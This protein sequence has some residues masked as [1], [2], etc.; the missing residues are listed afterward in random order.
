MRW[1][2]EHGM[3]VRRFGAGPEV[4]WLHGLGEWSQSFDVVAARRALAGFSHVLPDLPGYGRSPWSDDDRGDGS[5][6]PGSLEQLADQLVEWLGD[7]RPALIGAS[8]GGVLAT[9]VAERTAV[10]AVIDVDGNLSLGDC[11]FSSK[12]LAYSAD[13]FVASGFA[14]L[15]TEIYDA[16]RTDRALRGY[17]AAISAASPRVFH[18]HARELVALSES[19]Q[20]APRLAALQAPALFIA[21]IPRGICERSRDLL[22]RHGVPWIGL[23]PAGHW[24]HLDQPDAFAASVVAF[25]DEAL[26]T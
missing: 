26:S 9:L 17:H 20:L 22:D 4:V 14:A 24:V 13:E 6:R 18:R 8:M 21:G 23:E 7:R 15:R 3:M 12:A 5:D 19:E 2:L 10:R 1:A 25:L 16:G 11:T